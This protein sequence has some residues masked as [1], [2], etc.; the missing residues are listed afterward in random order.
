MLARKTNKRENIMNA[1][2]TVTSQVAEARIFEALTGRT[3]KTT[4]HPSEN[5]A[6]DAALLHQPLQLNIRHENF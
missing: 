2:I 4:Y 5:A 3:I 6:V 1:E